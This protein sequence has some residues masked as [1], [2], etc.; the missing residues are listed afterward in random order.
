M[1]LKSKPELLSRDV[2]Q[3]AWGDGIRIYASTWEEP[4][5]TTHTWRRDASTLALRYSD[6]PAAPYTFTTLKPACAG[7]VV[8]GE[9]LWVAAYSP[10]G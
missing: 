4:D 9:A 5:E 2:R 7:F 1:Q 10:N 3:Y 8:A 6:S